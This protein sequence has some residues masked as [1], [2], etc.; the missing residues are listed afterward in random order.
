MPYEYPIK[1]NARI[2]TESISSV[3]L[4]VHE[5]WDCINKKIVNA[6]TQAF[7]LNFK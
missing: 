7:A 4:F 1:S 5:P 3:C 6:F 2:E